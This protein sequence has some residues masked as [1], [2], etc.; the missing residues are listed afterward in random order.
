MTPSVPLLP[1]PLIDCVVWHD[2][3]AWRAALDTTELHRAAT[4]SGK[5]GGQH[6]DSGALAEFTPMTNYKAERKWV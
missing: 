1:G 5:A 2:G 4:D 3:A 6:G